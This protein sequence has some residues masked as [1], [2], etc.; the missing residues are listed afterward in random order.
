[1]SSGTG[2]ATELLQAEHLKSLGVTGAG[3]ASP[4]PVAPVVQAPAAPAAPEKAIEVL[5]ADPRVVALEQLPDEELAKE[6]IAKG[7]KLQKDWNR[8]RIIGEILSP[9]AAAPAAPT[10]P[11]PPPKAD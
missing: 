2:R 9:K 8:T 10:A 6:A 5:E 7:V 11:P 1:M 3:T 4:A